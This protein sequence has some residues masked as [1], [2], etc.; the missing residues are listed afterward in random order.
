MA[1]EA[2][3]PSQG[4]GWN[5]ALAKTATFSSDSATDQLHSHPTIL[6]APPPEKK[7]LAAHSAPH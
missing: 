2:G 5:T 6:T 7:Q 3:V 4:K 1:G